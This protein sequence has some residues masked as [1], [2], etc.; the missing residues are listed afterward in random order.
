MAQK[1]T[2]RK[3]YKFANNAIGWAPGGPFDRLGPYAKVQNCPI[4]ESNYR[5][6][7]YATNYADSF[8]SI[9]AYTRIRGKHVGG[10]FT[11]ENDCIR[12]HPNQTQ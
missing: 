3:Q 1:F 11:R 10:F 6:T 5:L 12:F 9:P 2:A 4:G 8:F 7:C